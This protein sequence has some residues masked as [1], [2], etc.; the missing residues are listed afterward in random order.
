M[1]FADNVMLISEE[2]D[3]SVKLID[4][5]M[6]IGLDW[7]NES[8]VGN[9]IMGTEGYFSPESLTRVRYSVSMYVCISNHEI[10][11]H[12][13]SRCNTVINPMSGSWD[14]F[15]MLCW[16]DT[17]PSILTKNTELILCGEGTI[18]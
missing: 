10:S 14:V 3:S 17:H 16:L 15:Y 18:P 12:M 5:G 2:D 13:F 8:L 9:S 11:F 7:P 1:Y 6:M 4:F